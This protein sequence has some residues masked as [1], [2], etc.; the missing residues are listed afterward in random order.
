MPAQVP[1]KIDDKFI[2]DFLNKA[3]GTLKNYAVRQYDHESFIKSAMLA[4]VEN[5]TLREC[6]KTDQ[7]KLSLFGALRFASSTGLS[8]NPQE[9]KAALIAY[10]G[11]VQYQIMK[12]GIVELALSSGMVDFV[13]AD[14]VRERDKFE[15]SKSMSGDNYEYAPA[16]TDRGDVIGFFAGCKL[17]SG[18]THVKYMTRQEVEEM[19]DKYSAMFKAKPEASPW[20]KSFNGMGIKT[21]LKSLFRNLS[22]STALDDALGNDEKTGA[23]IDI[24]DGGWTSEEVKTE[25]EQKPAPAPAQ[26]KMDF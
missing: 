2:G 11:K 4:I 16:K 14:I 9:G 24:T 8:L 15:L 7:G 20:S 5:E 17:K 3:H 10:G 23:V 25:L 22:I 19:R 18:S 21:V 12:N 26:G 1:A 13:T 6:L